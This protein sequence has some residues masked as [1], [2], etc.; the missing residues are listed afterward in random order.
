MSELVSVEPRRAKFIEQATAILERIPEA[1]AEVNMR[2]FIQK[3]PLSTFI[4]WNI[5]GIN[6]IVQE[7]I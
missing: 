5:L 2:D 4:I 6:I 3:I 1:S 7:W